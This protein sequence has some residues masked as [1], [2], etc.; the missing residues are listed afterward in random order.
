MQ[1][2]NLPRTSIKVSRMCLGTMM[3][4][5]QTNEA[6]S[7]AIM[8]YAFEQGVNF[9]DTASYYLEGEGEKVVGKGLKGRREKIILAT[10]VFGKVGDDMND[11]GLNRRHIINC[12]EGSLKRLGTDYI[13]L[14]YMHSPDHETEVEETLDTLTTLVRD[15]KIRYIGISN[16]AAWQVADIVAICDKRG[17]IK[18]IIS[19]NV[20]NLLLR[21]VERE[22][23]PCLKAYK[24]GMSVYNPIA[25][26]LLSGKYKSKELVENTR[27]TNNKLYYDRYWSDKYFEGL[28]K[29]T[30]IADKNGLPLIDMAPPEY[31]CIGTRS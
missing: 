1:Y 18:P 13:D 12:T 6:D 25:A 2:I 31:A 8:D 28:G 14:M 15:G 10:K 3:F 26:G 17:Y 23:L 22:L 5:G 20:Y 29:L 9:W 27:F 7:K 24:I 30:A 16:Y 11:Q 19:Q 4:G 21:D